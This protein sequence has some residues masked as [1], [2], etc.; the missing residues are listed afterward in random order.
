M[1]F[2]ASSTI[3]EIMNGKPNAS[4]ILSKHAG[5]PID[6]SQLQMAM[7]MSVQQVANFVGWNQAKIEAFL[8]D[9]NA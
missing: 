7:G 4:E 8:K 2:T 5:Q 9:L 6:P 3:A 1:A